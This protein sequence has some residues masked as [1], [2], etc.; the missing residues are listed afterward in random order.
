MRLKAGPQLGDCPL[1]SSE[2]TTL[3]P[4]SKEFLMEVPVLTLPYPLP[5]LK[6]KSREDMT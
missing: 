4:D 6:Q 2:I 1:E 5:S 3:P